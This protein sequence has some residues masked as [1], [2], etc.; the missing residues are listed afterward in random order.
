MPTNAA[1]STGVKGGPARSESA[2][3]MFDERK[4]P[5][6]PTGLRPDVRS[7]AKHLLEHNVHL[8]DPSQLAPL[9]RLARLYGD[10]ELMNQRL[11]VEGF[12]VVKPNGDEKINPVA[13][14]RD[15][16]MRNAITLERQL[17]I[18]FTARGAGVKKSE[19]VKPAA[20]PKTAG[21][22]RKLQLA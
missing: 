22:V 19:S 21:N 12:T 18:T 13:S 20:A 15:S 3:S 5:R 14:A 11:E 6:L 4:P 9:L 8:W 17:S 2:G 7:H 10:I 16:A 1:R